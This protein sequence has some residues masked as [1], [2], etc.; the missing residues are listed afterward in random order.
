MKNCEKLEK[1][2]GVLYFVFD[3]D[4]FLYSK[5]AEQ[6]AKLVKKFLGLP[7]TIITD[8]QT[9]ID[10]DV[11]NIIRVNTD[12][13]IT[14]TR[15]SSSVGHK[16]TWRNG[17]RYLAYSLSPYDETF[18]LDIDYLVLNNNLL[19]L[20]ET[21]L[22]YCLYKNNQYIDIETNHVE[23]M[24]IFSLPYLWAT[25]VFFRK[26][27]ASEL[28][29]DLVKRV[30]FNYSY[31]RALYNISAG[32]YRNDYAFTIADNVLQGYQ[33]STHIP[34]ILNTVTKNIKNLTYRNNTVSVRYQDT[35]LVLPMNDLHVLDKI[36]LQSENFKLFTTEVIS[37]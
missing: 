21:S 24:G 37:A 30:Q 25:A 34:W 22:D 19:K 18:V 36:F 13:E 33:Q 11:D 9:N 35:A 28:L 7:I 26:T 15:Y 31:Y 10:F 27:K 6:S 12:N 8:Q 5:I 17:Y 1:S 3:T 32:N 14:N 29:F 20:S 23:T 16:T 2:K 4:Q